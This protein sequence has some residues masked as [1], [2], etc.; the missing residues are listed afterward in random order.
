MV[1][2]I[3][4]KYLLQTEGDWIIDWREPLLH[5]VVK[6]YHYVRDVIAKLK[7]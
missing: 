2:E 6:N 3:K 5:Y 7:D 4:G 1:V